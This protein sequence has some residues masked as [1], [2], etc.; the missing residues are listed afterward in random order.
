MHNLW[1]RA[2]W[3]YD[4]RAVLRNHKLH[5]NE[6]FRINP[7]TK[8]F[9]FDNFGLSPKYVRQIHDILLKYKISFIHAY[10]SAAYQFCLLSKE[11]GLDLGFI[12]AFLCGSEGIMD[13]QKKLIVDDFGLKLFSWYG[14][15]EKLVLGGYCENTNHYHIEPHYGFFELIGKNNQ[16]IVNPGEFGE[17]V[18]TTLHNFGMPLIRYKTGDF[19]E[20]VGDHCEACGRKMPIIKNIKGRWDKNQIYKKDGTYISTT[21]LNLHNELYQ[22]INGIQYIQK[23]PGSLKV[24]II[25]GNNFRYDHEIVF[26]KHFSD[27]MGPDSEVIVEYVDSLLFQPN[28]KFV[29]LISNI[30]I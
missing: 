1:M 6:V 9:I 13:F 19:A 23:D 21:A 12:K 11:E 26:K 25:K 7:I 18:G 5:E 29:Q 10:P 14:H 4:S 27:A 17:I 16:P 30:K 3:N 15:S 28:G 2:G 8:E 22:I 20:Y 24:L